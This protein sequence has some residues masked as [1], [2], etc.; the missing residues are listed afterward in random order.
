MDYVVGNLDIRLPWAWKYHFIENRFRMTET[1]R[2]LAAV[3]FTDIVGFTKLSAS[4]ENK[5][6][7]LL[8]TQRDL[9]KP[10]VDKFNGE[11]CY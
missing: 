9:L 2:K 8:D 7:E 6:F 4:D 11:W 3:V 1:T 5:A 10:I